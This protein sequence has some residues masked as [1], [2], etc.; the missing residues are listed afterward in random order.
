[1]RIMQLSLGALTEG[2]LITKSIQWLGVKSEHLAFR[3]DAIASRELDVN[4]SQRRPGPSTFESSST[5][6]LRDR[7]RATNMVKEIDEDSTE[8]DRDCRREL[9]VMLFLGI[10]A[11]IQ[12]VD[13]TGDMSRWL[14]EHMGTL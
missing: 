5:L 10:K 3:Q 4:G 12:A 1:M 11:E 8:N 9:Q 13:N 14:D 2:R 6:T 7:T